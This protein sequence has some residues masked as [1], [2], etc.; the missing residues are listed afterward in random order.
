MTITRHEPT[1]ILSNVV[2]ANGFVFT[3]GV[4]AD[5]PTL[6]AK[7]QTEQILKRIDQ[8]LGLCGTDKS[9]IVTATIW[10]TDIRNREPMNEAWKAWTGGKDLPAR[11]CIEAKLADPRLL[12]EIAVTAAK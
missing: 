12:V 10:V 7:G 9:K 6:D 4:T 11:A 1:A 8:L 5:D 2:E 3:A